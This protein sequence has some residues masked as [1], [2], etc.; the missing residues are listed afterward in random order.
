M[1]LITAGRVSI[2]RIADEKKRSMNPSEITAM[3]FV[4]SDLNIFPKEIPRNMNSDVVK[5]N[6]GI[7]RTKEDVMFS[8]KKK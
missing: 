1:L 8:L 4:S 5:N 7:A 2:G 3:V 6:A